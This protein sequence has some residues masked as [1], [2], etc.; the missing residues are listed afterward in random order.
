MC[1]AGGEA[2]ACPCAGRGQTGE[3]R[4]HIP[5]TAE[6]CYHRLRTG[7]PLMRIARNRADALLKPT[8]SSR[9]RSPRLILAEPGQMNLI[10]PSPS[11]QI[12]T[13]PQNPSETEKSRQTD[14]R[15]PRP[16]APPPLTTLSDQRNPGLLSPPL[17]TL[18]G[19]RNPGLR[20]PPLTTLTG[21]RNPGLRSPPADHIEWSV[22]S[23]SPLSPA[24]HL[25]WSAESGSGSDS[26]EHSMCSEAG[27][28][29][30]CPCAGRGQRGA[31]GA[32]SP[33]RRSSPPSR[34]DT[35]A[36]R[37]GR[38]SRIYAPVS[39]ARAKSRRHTDGLRNRP[40][41]LRRRD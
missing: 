1:S 27:D 11:D 7:V 4:R 24:D 40:L 6:P 5:D 18:S 33:D 19:Q 9:P 28:A 17:T 22:E 15:R 21:Q 8:G 16:T 10:A 29:A 30:A 20:S 37:Q 25:E 26:V 41:P 3:G 35:A 2:A 31:P 39:S 34:R 38:S 23:G 32:P 12:G 14:H 36:G 13:T